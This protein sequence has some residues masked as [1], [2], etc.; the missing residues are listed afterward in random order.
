VFKPVLPPPDPDLNRPGLEF[1]ARPW[2]AFAD[3]TYQSPTINN[4]RDLTTVQ[5]FVSAEDVAVWIYDSRSGRVV[6]KLRLSEP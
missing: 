3:T 6:R 4:P 1:L 5:H 2:L